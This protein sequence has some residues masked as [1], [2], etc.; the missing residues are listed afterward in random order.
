MKALKND[1]SIFAKQ[2]STAIAE[3]YGSNSNPSNQSLLELY[4]FIGQHLVICIGAVEIT[5][6]AEVAKGEALQRRK[7][8]GEHFG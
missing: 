5:H 4:T 8:Y 2:I 6:P 1:G 7:L 3:C